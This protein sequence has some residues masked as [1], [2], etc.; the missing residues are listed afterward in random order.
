[1]LEDHI[2]INRPKFNKTVIEHVRFKRY[3]GLSKRFKVSTL[4]FTL[5]C[6]C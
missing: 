2:L 6:Y 4:Y 5:C 3:L 1:M